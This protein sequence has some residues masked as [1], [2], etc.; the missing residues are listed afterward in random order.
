MKM[1]YYMSITTLKTLFFYAV[2]FI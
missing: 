1:K 2:H